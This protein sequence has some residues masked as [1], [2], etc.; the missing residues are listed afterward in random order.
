MKAIGEERDQFAEHV[1]GA[2]KAMQQE[3]CRGPGR[4]GSAVEDAEAVDPSRAVIDGRHGRLPSG[5]SVGGSKY[6]LQQTTELRKNA[7]LYF[8]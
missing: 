2:W 3:Q 1:A 7:F 5:D 8:S 6:A 4:T